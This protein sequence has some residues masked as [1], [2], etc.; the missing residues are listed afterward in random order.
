MFAGASL[1]S[2]FVLSA[3]PSTCDS[4]GHDLLWGFWFTTLSKLNRKPYT[5]VS[6]MLGRVKFKVNG[7]CKSTYLLSILITDCVTW[8]R[9]KRSPGVSYPPS[10][11]MKTWRQGIHKSKTNLACSK[12]WNEF[13]FLLRGGAVVK[14]LLDTNSRSGRKN[15]LPFHTCTMCWSKSHSHLVAT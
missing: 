15:E 6:E 14:N 5:F 1:S 11:W 4:I 3:L 10:K 7:K 13:C 9:R 12:L 8:L 2:F